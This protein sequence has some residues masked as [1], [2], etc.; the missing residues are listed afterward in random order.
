MRHARYSTR[1]RIQ[2]MTMTM[3]AAWTLF[4]V[5]AIETVDDPTYGKQDIDRPTVTTPDPL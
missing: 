1:V 5:C 3:M 2:Y 4:G